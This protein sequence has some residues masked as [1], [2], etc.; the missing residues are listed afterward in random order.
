MWK[1][2]HFILLSLCIIIALATC[3]LHRYYRKIGNVIASSSYCS[4]NIG[5]V[6]AFI[7]YSYDNIGI[8]IASLSYA[9]RTGQKR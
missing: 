6:I 3:V 9:L 8:V 7:S 4:W 5:T 2:Y 1:R